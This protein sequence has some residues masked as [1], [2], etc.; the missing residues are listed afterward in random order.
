MASE[1]LWDKSGRL[2]TELL[3][4]GDVDEYKRYRSLLTRNKDVFYA[5]LVRTVASAASYFLIENGILRAMKSQVT[6]PRWVI[7]RDSL[8][9]HAAA[10][11][12]ELQRSMQTRHPIFMMTFIISPCPMN[13][14]LGMFIVESHSE[15]KRTWDLRRHVDVASWIPVEMPSDAATERRGDVEGGEAASSSET[16]TAAPA[17]SSSETATAAPAVPR[18]LPV[19]DEPRRLTRGCPLRFSHNGDDFDSLLECIHREAFR[20]LG[21]KYLVTRNIFQLG[22]LL[23]E[24]SQKQYTTDGILYAAVGASSASPQVFHVE[25]KPGPLSVE[26]GERCKALCEFLNQHVLCV[27]GG[28]I[29]DARVKEETAMPTAVPRPRHSFCVEMSVYLAQGV[30]VAPLY[31]PSVM[32]HFGEGACSTPFLSAFHTAD[33]RQWEETRLRLLRVYH[34]ATKDAGRFARCPDPY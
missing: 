11:L 2:R 18:V 27:S 22:H 25:I 19:L 34:L 15:D 6:S 28:N 4:Q 32:W 9:V 26:E 7:Y 1:E 17:A 10:N 23:G 14:P 5:D 16:A 20:R 12:T 30:G 21:L 29:S 13:L 31:C 8:T 3:A 24:Q 33:P